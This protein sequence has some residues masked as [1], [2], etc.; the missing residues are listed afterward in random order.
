MS[1]ARLQQLFV[2]LILQLLIAKPTVATSD[3]SYDCSPDAKKIR[4]LTI[5]PFKKWHS[6]RMSSSEA[7]DFDDE[8]PLTAKRNYLN[9]PTFEQVL[10]LLGKKEAHRVMCLN[11]K[12]ESQIRAI[13]KGI[14]NVRWSST[15]SLLQ[16]AQQHVL[17]EEF[18]ESTKPV[19]PFESCRHKARVYAQAFKLS[20]PLSEEGIKFARQMA[21]QSDMLMEFFGNGEVLTKEAATSIAQ[22]YF[23]LASLLDDRD[24]DK[25]IYIKK[26]AEFYRA[27]IQTFEMDMVPSSEDVITFVQGTYSV[28]C[29]VNDLLHCKNAKQTYNHKLSQLKKIGLNI[30][31]VHNTN[32]MNELYKW[33]SEL[34]ALSIQ[35]DSINT[36]QDNNYIEAFASHVNQCPLLQDKEN[37]TPPNEHSDLDAVMS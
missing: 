12:I 35:A 24:K 22:S 4:L 7:D 32:T 9:L 11:R 27:M 21:I 3:S 34:F 29:Q 1:T 13:D 33:A 2:L 16:Q 25:A 6:H 14:A 19:T 8:L 15:A 31:Q 5:S 37:R 36:A 26:S 28:L 30:E 18:H 17:N 23:T 10:L 20:N